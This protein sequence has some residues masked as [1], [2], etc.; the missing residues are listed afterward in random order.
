[1]KEKQGKKSKK[2]GKLIWIGSTSLLLVIITLASYLLGV[3][4]LGF[5]LS[6]IIFLIIIYYFVKPTEEEKEQYGFPRAR[7]K[8][9]EEKGSQK[10]GEK[11]LIV[12]LSGK[13]E[14]EKSHR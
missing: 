9:S 5:L 6:F 2:E 11:K 14:K 4:M 8:Q 12:D 13:A 1:M 7:R 3:F 10:E